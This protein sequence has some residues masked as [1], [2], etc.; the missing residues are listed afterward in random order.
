MRETEIK[1][2]NKS[3]KVATRHGGKGMELEIRGPVF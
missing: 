1:D 2:M 3:A